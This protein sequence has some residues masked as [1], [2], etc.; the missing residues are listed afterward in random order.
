MVA[1]AKLTLPKP[2][3]LIM[4]DRSMAGATNDG[5]RGGGMGFFPLS[6]FIGAMAM[7]RGGEGLRL[8]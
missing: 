7:G 8:G 3:R 4:I 1:R 2:S 5:E 6:S